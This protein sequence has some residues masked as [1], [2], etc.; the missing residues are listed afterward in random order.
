MAAPSAKRRVQNAVITGAANDPYWANVVLLLG[1]KGPNGS[2]SF[3][4]S[5]LAAHVM[6]AGGT[7][8]ISTAQFKFP[9]SSAAFLAGAG[10]VSTPDSTDWWLE[11]GDF[12]IECWYRPSSIG[13]R[14]LLCGQANVGATAYRNVLEVNAAGRLVYQGTGSATVTV[15]GTT[16]MSALN[17]YFLAAT[18][19]GTSYRVFVQGNL[20]TTVVSAAT[21]TDFPGDF[22]VGRMGAFG[23]LLANGYLEQF[24][25]TKGVARYTASFTPPTA[26][27]PTS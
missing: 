3:P 11:P 12:T 15:T 17:W 1:C 20:D 5:S 24:R 4:D 26:P 22:T 6:T 14:Q 16:V 8:Q 21:F 23:G 7:G 18:K 27:F 13:T 10:Y 2:T 25:I 9:S 19:S